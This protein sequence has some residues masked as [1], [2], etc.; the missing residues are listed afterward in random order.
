MIG[1]RGRI[2]LSIAC[3]WFLFCSSNAAAGVGDQEPANLV[4]NLPARMLYV[5][6]ENTI[7]ASYP[8]AIGKPSTPTPIGEFTVALKQVNPWWIPEPGDEPVPPGPYNPLGTRWM[9]LDLP[10]YGLHGTNAP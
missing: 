1:V 4:L 9:G 5:Y 10:S 7:S 2:I 3:V 6:H 8:V